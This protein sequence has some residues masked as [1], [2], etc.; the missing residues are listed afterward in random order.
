MREDVSVPRTTARA[1]LDAII[2]EPFAGHDRT[3][4]KEI[5]AKGPTKIYKDLKTLLKSLPTDQA[6]VNHNPPIST[7]PNSGRVK[8]E[9]KNVTVAACWV[10][11]VRHETDNDFHVILGSAKSAGASVFMNAEICGIPKTGPSIQTLTQVRQAFVSLLGL[12]AI[13]D[14]Y[15]GYLKFNPPL[16]VKV[17]GSLFYDV[18]HKPGVVGPPGLRPQTSWEIHPLTI[19]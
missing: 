12:K 10:H 5:V 18:D 8:E 15:K 7:S 9:N 1:S 3:K 16:S 14:A 19:I 2:S 4:A 11:A 17:S 13:L 6:M